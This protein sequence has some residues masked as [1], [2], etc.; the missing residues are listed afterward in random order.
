M[1]T[2]TFV[3]DRSVTRYHGHVPTR[4]SRAPTLPREERERRVLDTAAERFY[5]RGVHE[6][7]MD[8]L[9]RAT[10]L[11]K[12]TVYRLFSTKDELI[13]AYLRRL[14]SEI[15]AAIDAEI[16]RHTN[17]PCDALDAILSAIEQDVGRSTF[18]GCA[19]NK[20]ASIEFPTLGTRRARSRG[21]TAC[22]C[23]VGWWRWRS[24]RARA[25]ASGSARSWR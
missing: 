22:S 17:R 16:D 5:S 10:G 8:E 9:V 3:S 18:R 7:G 20:N 25:R 11:G 23:T 4:S 6:V 14:A 2:L 12:A 15:L 19:F 21:T 13:G 1:T 24:R